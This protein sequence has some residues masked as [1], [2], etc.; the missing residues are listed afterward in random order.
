MTPA[1]TARI[2][3]VVT[4]VVVVLAML[5]A[6]HQLGSGH[7]VTAT[8]RKR[9]ESEGGP[10]RV[11][12]EVVGQPRDVEVLADGVSLGITPV[13]LTL[14]QVMDA[15]R[16]RQE[17]QDQIVASAPGTWQ[18]HD[19]RFEHYDNVSLR[20]SARMWF[21]RVENPSIQG[22]QD[23]YLEFRIAGEAALTDVGPEVAPDG[24]RDISVI[25]NVILPQWQRN[26]G[27]L[28]AQARL[29]DYQV[30]EAWCEAFASY[31]DRGWV[32]LEREMTDEP[33]LAEL[34]DAVVRYLWQIDERLSPEQA[35][36]R[37]LSVTD[38]ARQYRYDADSYQ[39]RAVELLACLVDIRRL[40]TELKS[41]ARLRGERLLAT[42]RERWQSGTGVRTR[43]IRKLFGVDTALAVLW[44]AAVTADRHSDDA[45]NRLEQE[46]APLLLRF[47]EGKQRG[48]TVAM[49]MAHQLGGSHLDRFLLAQ[50]WRASVRQQGTLSDRDPQNA[51]RFGSRTINRWLAELLTLDSPAGRQW[52]REHRDMIQQLAADSLQLSPESASLD[53]GQQQWQEFSLRLTLSGD[54]CP[55]AHLDCLF[56]DGP[57]DGPSAAMQFWPEYRRLVDQQKSLTGYRIM[58]L[59]FG[60]LASMWPEST[61]QMF[62]EAVR[63]FVPGM[64]SQSLR[65][66]PETLA[67]TDQFEILE[68]MKQAVAEVP[69]TDT[70]RRIHKTEQ[71]IIAY[72]RRAFFTQQLRL[73]CPAAAELIVRNYLDT[74]SADSLAERLDN[75]G[76]YQAEDALVTAFARCE[77]SRFRLSALTCILNV[78]SPERMPLLSALEAD[79][80]ADVAQRAAEVRRLLE[81]LTEQPSADLACPARLVVWGTPNGSP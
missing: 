35:L 24:E 41:A 68:A 52:R 28:I 65:L 32:R 21:G 54:I 9:P 62:V 42:Y 22:L 70:E 18:T 25:A 1:R 3:A 2:V 7:G 74:W 76:Y 17:Y 20:R 56:I 12:I 58:Q 29:A 75:T 34:Q 19:D 59:R 81:D 10:Q 27:R 46:I 39:G 50:D 69:I 72:R 66:L 40:S 23:V 37:L 73:D 8:A 80:Q 71:D 67:D 49:R 51:S 44:H 57:S 30:D 45:V 6:V 63:D 14:Q 13:D 5:R 77:D 61:P 53:D 60:Y 78:P 55:P 36:Q 31:G 15:A 38:A 4:V 79:E 48:V 11:R 16:R 33:R 64:N 43:Q 47:A 26:M